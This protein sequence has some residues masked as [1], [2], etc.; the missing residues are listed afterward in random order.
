MVDELPRENELGSAYEDASPLHR[1]WFD[2]APSDQWMKV[3]LFKALPASRG[4]DRDASP[5]EFAEA[6]RKLKEWLLYELSVQRYRAIG[7]VEVD[8]EYDDSEGTRYRYDEVSPY[9]A[10]P[11]CVRWPDSKI[12]YARSEYRNVRVLPA[13]VASEGTAKPEAITVGGE[14]QSTRSASGP[15]VGMEVDGAEAR[16]EAVWRDFEVRRA[17][18]EATPKKKRRQGYAPYFIE[19]VRSILFDDHVSIYEVS[20]RQ[21]VILIQQKLWKTIGF[22]FEENKSPDQE[23]VRVFLKKYFPDWPLQ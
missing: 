14:A 11:R 13:D 1:A 17:E 20:Q 15:K 21:S 12:V 18:I 3:G 16:R 7:L 4:G 6:E 19:A 9:A 8:Y 10:D 22:R 2:F 23:T 5:E